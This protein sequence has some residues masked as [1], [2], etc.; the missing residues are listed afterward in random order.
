MDLTG[1]DQT[2][3]DAETM[4][5]DFEKLPDGTYQVF[6]DEANLTETK[7]KQTPMLTWKLKIM[8]GPFEGRLLFKNAVIT[9]KTL[10]FIKTDLSICGMTLGK[11]SDLPESLHLLLNTKLEVKTVTKKYVNHKNEEK[12]AQNIWI[13]RKLDSGNST[14]SGDDIPF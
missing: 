1:F 12:E 9:D 11:F 13:Q 10:P 8:T 3:E 2:Y 4:G 14:V 7:E 6:V 5:E